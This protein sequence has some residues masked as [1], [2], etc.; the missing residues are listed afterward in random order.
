M[1][2]AHWQEK[3]CNYGV[4]GRMSRRSVKLLPRSTQQHRQVGC[5]RVSPSLAA[6]DTALIYTAV[7]TDCTP[8]SILTVYMYTN[9][10]DTDC[11]M[12]RPHV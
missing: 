5:T 2:L 8:L 3:G 1:G 12:Q 9:V 4:V 11:H 10:K 6:L 7:Y